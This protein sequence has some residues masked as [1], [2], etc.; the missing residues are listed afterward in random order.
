MT[1]FVYK[2]LT[3]NLEIGNTPVWVSL[4]IW[5]LGHVRDTKFGAIVVNEKL[6]NAA[7]FQGYNFYHFWI[8]KEKPIKITPTTQIK[9][10][11]VNLFVSNKFRQL[12]SR[13][14][15]RNLVF[16]R[17]IWIFQYTF[18]DVAGFLDLPLYKCKTELALKVPWCIPY[19][20]VSIIRFR[21]SAHWPVF[22]TGFGWMTNSWSIKTGHI[23][24]EAAKRITLNR[25]PVSDKPKVVTENTSKILWKYS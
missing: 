11:C 1:L 9:S 23:N 24:A 15:S 4:N 13:S 7:K 8:I 6:L 14:G 21:R 16:S 20:S 18:T 19:W 22:E 25:C 10:C 12:Q 17:N 5:R 2:R 3:R